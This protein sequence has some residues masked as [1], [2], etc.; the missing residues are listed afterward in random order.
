[1][2]DHCGVPRS[3]ASFLGTWQL[4]YFGFTHCPD[5]CPQQLER[6]TKVL[7]LVE[8]ERPGARL[9]PMFM[10]CDPGRDS[11]QRCREA[12]ADFHP[13]ILGMTGCPSQIKALTKKYK[14]FFSEP[15]A[16][17]VSTGDYI[18]DHSIATFLF[19]PQGN[20]VEFWSSHHE[21]EAMCER[22]VTEM[23]AWN[24]RVKPFG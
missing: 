20:F 4:I 3:Q 23:D 15:S 6:L 5:V 16:E 22:L 12:V 19:D 11:V 10:C 21:P 14:V 8:K 7:N 2:I 18:V 13:T 24:T 1:M 17:D 9:S